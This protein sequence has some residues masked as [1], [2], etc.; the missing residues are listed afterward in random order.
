MRGIDPSRLVFAPRV[1]LREH[2][3][4]HCHADLFLDTLPYNAH[5]TA[6]DALWIGVPIVTCVGSAM[7]G[8]LGGSQL[9]ALGLPELVTT[10]L[11]DYEALALRLARRPDELSALR[12]RLAANRHTQP[13]FDMTSYA[14]DF[15]DCV[16]RVWRDH[17]DE[18]TSA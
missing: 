6:N 18:P 9:T 13:L 3:A 7:A 10:S 1:A 15:A 8:R 17:A 5:T 11:P 12:A 16:I 14:R 2:L 4:R